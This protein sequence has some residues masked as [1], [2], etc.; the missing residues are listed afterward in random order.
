[1]DGIFAFR[2]GKVVEL[3]FTWGAV[4]APSYLMKNKMGKLPDELEA[5]KHRD[6]DDRVR[7]NPAP[8]LARRNVEFVPLACTY[9]TNQ[10][11]KSFEKLM[12]EVKKEVNPSKD[13]DEHIHGGQYDRAKLQ[14]HWLRGRLGA[15]AARFNSQAVTDWERKAAAAKDRQAQVD[16]RLLLNTAVRQFPQEMQVFDQDYGFGGEHGLYTDLRAEVTG[17]CRDLPEDMADDD[18]DQDEE[19]GNSAS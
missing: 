10:W 18:G 7:H 17:D 15:T 3:D 8:T 13:H 1:M 16:A 5:S 2:S 6:Y 12:K 19:D 4:T 14:L 11:G 9:P